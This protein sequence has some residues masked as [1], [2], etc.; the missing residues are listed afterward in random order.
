MSS[1]TT[2]WQL[3][4]QRLIP[5]WDPQVFARHASTFSAMATDWLQS[6]HETR[7]TATAPF[8]ASDLIARAT[9][10]MMERPELSQLLDFMYA[11]AR[12]LHASGYMG[13]QVPPPLPVSAI[14]NAASA[15]ANQ[16]SAVFEMSPSCTSIE[17]AV[18]RRLI[19][20]VGWD[21][22]QSDGIMTGGG[23]LANLTAILTAK[24]WTFRK[25]WTEGLDQ[26][27]RPA[28]LTSAD[29]HYS[30]ARA[31]GV[32]GI[33]TQN[34]IKVPLDPRRRM[35][36]TKIPDILQQSRDRGLTPFCVVASSGATPTGSFDELR[37]ISEICKRENLWL[38][39]DGAHGASAL[40]SAQHR[41]LVAGLDL[42]DSVTWD[43]HKMMFVPAL[44]TFLLYRNRDSS[45]STFAQDAP[46]LLDGKDE[47]RLWLDGALRTLEC[48]KQSLAMGVWGL[49]CMYGEEVFGDLFD[50]TCGLTRELWTMLK[51]D[52]LPLHEPQ[53]NIIC[54]QWRPPETHQWPEKKLN[55]LQNAIRQKMLSSHEFYTTTTVIDGKQA[56]RVTIMN[57]R[58][59]PTD[60]IG[61]LHHIGSVGR[62]FIGNDF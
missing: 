54:F 61:L 7:P 25:A 29:S 43:A 40:F 33:G 19:E 10:L 62:E 8:I 37:R 59:T 49:W 53:A 26:G 1:Q 52:F 21:P 44:S 17:R 16:S 55:E 45:L 9:Q 57:P 18:L 2:D 4:Q 5:L 50:V 32:L 31:A 24:N 11:G 38:H 30:I 48:T 13:H 34:V 58:I 3:A 42:A 46:Y 15:L 12:R 20:A 6:C 56:I 47:E 22:A 28:I 39:V 27:T 35:D 41:R 23:S 51:G 60:L 36:W 14:L